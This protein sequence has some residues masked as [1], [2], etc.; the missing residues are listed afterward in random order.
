M[1]KIGMRLLMP[2]LLAQKSGMLLAL[3]RK[4]EA[5]QNLEEALQFARQQDSRRSLWQVLANLVKLAPDDG[6][7][8]AYRQEGREVVEFIAGHISDEGLR[9]KFLSQPE[10]QALLVS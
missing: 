4:E 8:A 2:D 10:V 9:G 7:A 5:R 1:R 3:D 6:K